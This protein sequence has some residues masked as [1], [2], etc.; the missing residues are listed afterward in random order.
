[1][2]R[3]SAAHHGI[4]SSPPR[5]RSSSAVSAC[6]GLANLEPRDRLPLPNTMEWPMTSKPEGVVAEA[7]HGECSCARE[8]LRSPRFGRRP[9]GR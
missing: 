7:G 1:M 3:E 9:S 8:L 2:A 5:E 6:H 4:R